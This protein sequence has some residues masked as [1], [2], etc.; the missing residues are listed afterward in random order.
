MQKTYQ[1]K[2]PKDLFKVKMWAL[3]PMP[4]SG[5]AKSATENQLRQPSKKRMRNTPTLLD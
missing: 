2:F 1:K 5:I 4:P 3:S